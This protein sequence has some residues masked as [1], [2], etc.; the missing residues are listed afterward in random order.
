MFGLMQDLPLTTNWI[1]ERGERFYGAKTVTTKTWRRFLVERGDAV[2]I[3]PF[4]AHVRLRLSR[5]SRPP[6]HGSHGRWC[7]LGFR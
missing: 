4:T 2:A 1:L 5:N 3:P 6:W 7:G